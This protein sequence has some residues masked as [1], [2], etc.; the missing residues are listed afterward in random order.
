MHSGYE[1]SMPVCHMWDKNTKKVSFSTYLTGNTCIYAL[2]T[3]LSYS[4]SKTMM[5]SDNDDNIDNIGY[6]LNELI[7]PQKHQ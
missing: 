7:C 4:I 3:T 2:S 1:F 6:Q 5:F